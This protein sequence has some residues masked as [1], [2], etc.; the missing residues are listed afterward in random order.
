MVSDV[1]WCPVI[2]E[3]LYLLHHRPASVIH[4]VGQNYPHR[5]QEAATGILFAL[6]G[7]HEGCHTML[8]TQN[9]SCMRFTA[10]RTEIWIIIHNRLGHPSGRAHW[11]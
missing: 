3:L 8:K 9:K 4:F 5:Y 10:W 2:V 11:G 1:R 7:H 6:R